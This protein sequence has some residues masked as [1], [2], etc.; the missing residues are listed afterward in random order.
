[1]RDILLG[2]LSTT[3]GQTSITLFSIWHIMYVVLI[4]GIIF[5]TVLLMKDKDEIRKKKLLNGMAVAVPA[6]YIA[7]FFMMPLAH[8][9]FSIDVDKLPFHICTIMAFFIPFV[10]FNHRFKAL[11]TPVVCLSLV[12]SLMYI[13]YPGT[14][15]GDVLPWCYKVVQTFLYHGLM[16]GWGI[17]SLTLGGVRLRYRGIWKE[18]IFILCMVAWASFGNAVYSTE[19]HIY[20][21]FFVNGVTFPFIPDFLMIPTVIVAVFGMCALIYAIYYGAEALYL[22]H[23]RRQETALK[24]PSDHAF[25]RRG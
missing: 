3:R 4:L 20:D 8:S 14:A 25:L 12:A 6:V 22:K 10:Q 18:L 23:L 11:K 24:D 21:W 19:N 17:M 2:L 16:L 5:I 9:D 7:D 1:M 13:T 15:I